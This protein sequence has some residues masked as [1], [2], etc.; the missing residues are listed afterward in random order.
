[1][2]CSARGNKQTNKQTNKQDSIVVELDK[3]VGVELLDV[4]VTS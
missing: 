1:M 3:K 2:F 4:K